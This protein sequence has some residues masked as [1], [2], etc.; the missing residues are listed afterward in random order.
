MT[1]QDLFLR[2]N[3]LRH[4]GIEHSGD[5]VPRV[6]LHGYLDLARTFSRVLSSLASG[7]RRVIAL[8]FRGHGETERAPEGSYYH[9]ADYLADVVGVL[10]ALDL[11][12]AH[13]VAHSMG[14]TV[15][16]MLAGALPDRVASSVPCH[17]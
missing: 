14:A 7:G 12:R 1:A 6:L 4:H 13:L 3:G 2:A 15:A 17:A 10:D 9:F 8:D 11:R 16:T 5:G